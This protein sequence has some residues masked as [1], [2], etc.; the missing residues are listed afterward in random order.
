MASGFITLRDGRCLSVRWRWHDE[1]VAAVAAALDQNGAEPALA[2]WLRSRLPRAEDQEDLGYGPWRRVLDGAIVPRTLDLRAFAGAYQQ[3]FEDGVLR[4]AST[5]L[6]TER[7][8][9]VLARLAE[10]VVRSRRSDPPLE[11]SDCCVI[12][13]RDVERD[14]PAMDDGC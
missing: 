7:L 12:M 11:L 4:A 5:V 9:P 10:M 8:H 14:G 1:A 2:A 6:Q 3:A 13:P